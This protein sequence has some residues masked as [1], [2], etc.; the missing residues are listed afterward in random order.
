MALT[1]RQQIFDALI[2]RLK[3]ITTAGGYNTNITTKVDEW[4]TD[5]EAIITEEMPRLNVRDEIEQND[6]MTLAVPVMNRD[7][8]VSIEGFVTAVGTSLAAD[9]ARALY[10]DI[11]TALFVDQTLGGLCRMIRMIGDAPIVVGQ[12]AKTI[13]ALEAKILINYQ[14]RGR[15]PYTGVP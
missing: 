4:R 2:T 9:G 14:T 12:A 3:T 5:Y 10:G 13:A 15:T 8:T 1:L 11:E 7:I 6:E